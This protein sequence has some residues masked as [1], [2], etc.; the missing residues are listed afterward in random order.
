MNNRDYFPVN[1]E[2]FENL[3]HSS[4]PSE[5]PDEIVDAVTPWKKAIKR[6]LWG[7][8]FNTLTLN[9]FYLNYILPVIGTVLSPAI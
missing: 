1:E 9:F 5:P 3:L 8:A 2:A 6:V 4:V 7:L